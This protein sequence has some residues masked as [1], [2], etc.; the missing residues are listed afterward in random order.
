MEFS[1]EEAFDIIYELIVMSGLIG[2][3]I[4]YFLRVH[5]FV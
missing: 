1:L 4:Y 3:M 5:T 2:L